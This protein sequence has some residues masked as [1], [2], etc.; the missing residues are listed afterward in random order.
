MVCWDFLTLRATGTLT[1][2]RQTYPPA[3][4]LS[5]P[6]S[7][8]SLVSSQTLPWISGCRELHPLL[9]SSNPRTQ[10][11]PRCL[12]PAPT[13][14]GGTAPPRLLRGTFALGCG[15]SQCSSVLGRGQLASSLSGD[16]FFSFPFL[17]TLSPKSLQFPMGPR[18]VANSRQSS[19]IDLPTTDYRP[20]PLHLALKM[21]F[22]SHSHTP[23]SG[24][25]LSCF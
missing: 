7:C 14:G 15:C 9:P 23:H 5:L 6:R 21:S 11:R 19:C 17:E 18:L 13:P 22:K 20:A 2:R 16:V 24:Y 25:Y 3:P 12:P 8:D 10:Q 1:Y 4:P